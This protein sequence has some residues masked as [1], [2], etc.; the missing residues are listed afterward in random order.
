VSSLQR[1]LAAAATAF[2]FAAPAASAHATGCAGAGAP[3][4]SV[5]PAAAKRTI[6]CLVNVQRRAHHLPLLAENRSLDVSAQGW[7]QAMASSGNFSH[8][9]ADSNPATR[10]QAAGYDWMAVGENIAAGFRT[11]A[12]VVDAWM[13]S[14]GHCRNI[15]DPNF[16]NI[17]TGIV[18]TEFTQD[19]GTPLSSR[20]M[21]QDWGPADAVCGT[22]A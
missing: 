10:I 12:A 5:A 9:G 21:D 19:F 17:G 8:F 18:G 6:V 13:H 20:P 1:V 11:P 15:L 3:V 2:A 22:G 16:V 7:T 14:A 4:P